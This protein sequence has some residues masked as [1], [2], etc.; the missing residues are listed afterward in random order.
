[1]LPRR[2]GF[3]TL[4]SMSDDTDR[5]ARPYDR[6]HLLLRVAA[7]IVAGIPSTALI[8]LPLTQALTRR[9]HRETFLKRIHFMIPWARFC[10]ENTCRAELVVHG[11]EHL[12]QRSRGHLYV[13]NHQSYVDILVLMAALDTVAFLSKG[14][15]RHLPVIG[16]CAYCGGTVFF[17][18]GSKEERTRALDETLR[19]C[20]QSTA[21]VVFPE[22]TRSD[23]DELRPKIYPRA[24]QEAWRR[25]LRVLPVAVDGSGQ[26][27]P[28]AMDRIRLNQS[29][30][31]WIGPAR[32]PSYFDSSESFVEACWGDVATLFAQAKESRAA[33]K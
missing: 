6:A 33:N 24:M 9:F 14:L 12:P 13:S 30:A 7:T 32:D 8:P 1:M 17:K 20:H 28:K 5:P 10:V 26:V 16:R 31:V 19:M 23:N 21:V 29:V 11:I 4:S 27:I 25:G 3:G 15:V 2:D 18:R 22:G